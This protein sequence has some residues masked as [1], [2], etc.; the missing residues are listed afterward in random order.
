MIVRE[1]G[2]YMYHCVKPA[3]VLANDEVRDQYCQGKDCMAWVWHG[4]MN[5][6][7]GRCGLVDHRSQSS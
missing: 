1:D 3:V 4:P 2:A 6:E 5:E 7:R